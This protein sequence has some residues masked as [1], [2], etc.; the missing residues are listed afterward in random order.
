MTR[1]KLMA[2]MIA[3]VTCLLSLVSFLG[4][5]G[6]GPSDIV[7]SDL[8]YSP[9]AVPLMQLSTLNATYQY[10]APSGDLAEN[11][12]QWT[13]PNGRHAPAQMASLSKRGSTMGQVAGNLQLK[14]D[15]AGT[16][17]FTLW[18]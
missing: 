4:C 18:A 5:G 11:A 10:R 7:I 12:I 14:P 8:T 3:R 17:S 16:Y 1:G 2:R 9:S 15:T 13:A 6:D